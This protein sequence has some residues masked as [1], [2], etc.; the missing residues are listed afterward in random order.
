MSDDGKRN[1]RGG[2]TN[3]TKR[4]TTARDV[5]PNTPLPRH[6]QPTINHEKI[7][8][9]LAAAAKHVDDRKH[10]R[11]K[12]RKSGANLEEIVQLLKSGTDPASIQHEIE[13]AVEQ[14]RADIAKVNE[15]L[16]DLKKLKTIARE[17]LGLGTQTRST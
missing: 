1:R 7:E 9:Y 8:A 12:L 14:F 5:L 6:R 4:R 11:A 15:A 13:S 16:D 10:D 2:K 17:A 3:R